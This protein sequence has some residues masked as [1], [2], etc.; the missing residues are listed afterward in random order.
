[1]KYI[2]QYL[3]LTAFFVM[4]VQLTAQI[5]RGSMKEKGRDRIESMRIAFITEKLNLSTEEAQRFWPV[6]NEFKADERKIKQDGKPE[7]SLQDMTE[8]EAEQFITERF[9]SQDRQLQLEKKYYARMKDVISIR[10]IALL[11]Q[12]EID[13]KKRLVEAV[14]NRKLDNRPMRRNN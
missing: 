14:R 1:M 2:I 9:S 5:D 10:K 12:A 4:A 8:K 7:K 3:F 11:Y 6:Y 13:F